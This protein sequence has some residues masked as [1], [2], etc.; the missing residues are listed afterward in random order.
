MSE[1]RNQNQI[2]RLIRVLEVLGSLDFGDAY[3]KPERDCSGLCVFGLRR[4]DVEK[5]KLK[6]HG[7][8]NNINIS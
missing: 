4:L 1:D 6:L 3:R 5:R 2:V 8:I 7:E